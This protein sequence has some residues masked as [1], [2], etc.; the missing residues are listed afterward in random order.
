VNA[1][2][3]ERPSFIMCCDAFTPP[4]NKIT[5]GPWPKRR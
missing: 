3:S 5:L 4:C 2:A 1:S